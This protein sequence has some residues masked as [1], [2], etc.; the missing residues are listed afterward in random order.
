MRLVSLVY[1][2][3]NLSFRSCVHAGEIRR[4]GETSS[5]DD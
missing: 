1:V 4:A 3:D 5:R 2:E